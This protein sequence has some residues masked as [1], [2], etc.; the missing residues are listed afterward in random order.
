MTSP[1]APFKSERDF[2]PTT[3]TRRP[4]PSGSL[5]GPDRS[6]GWGSAAFFLLAVGCE[7]AFGWTVFVGGGRRVLFDF[8]IASACGAGTVFDVCR[9]VG[10]KLMGSRKPVTR[11]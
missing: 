6:A 9:F 10:R 2:S 1:T 7:G 4:I 11:T 5:A 8:A 3:R